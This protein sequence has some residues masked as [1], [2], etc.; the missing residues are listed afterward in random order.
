M[1]GQKPADV[2]VGAL[3]TQL[4]AKQTI[5]RLQEFTNRAII[6]RPHPEDPLGHRQIGIPHD[7][8]RRS[9]A[10]SLTDAFAVV[11]YNSNALTDATIAG[12]PTFALG[13]GSMVHKITNT[14]LTLIDNPRTFDREQWAYD[15]AWRQF[16]MQEMRSGLLWEYAIEK[17]IPVADTIAK[18]SIPT[19]SLTP[20]AETIAAM[21]AARSGELINAGT[22]EEFLTKHVESVST[23]PL[24]RRGRPRKVDAGQ[25]SS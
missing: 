9:I 19:T 6:Y 17:R 8:T 23:N 7:D 2:A 3:N 21:E 24:V 11:A 14:D 5:A 10:E 13:P 1:C 12:V 4:W 16:T 18:E 20:N 15:L 22:V 25:E